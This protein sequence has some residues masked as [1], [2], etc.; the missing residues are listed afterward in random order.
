[1]ARRTKPDKSWGETKTRRMW[2][3]T[4]YMH[5]RIVIF[6]NETPSFRNTCMACVRWCSTRHQYEIDI[7]HEV[8]VDTKLMW[9]TLFH[10]FTHIVECE[11]EPE[12]L[13]PKKL[14]DENCT[15]LAQT[16]GFAMAQ[17]MEELRFC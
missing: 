4:N 12:A 1:M 17:M 14:R 2:A 10:E 5:W 6:D 13:S 9:S 3:R 11:V 15:R 7:A 8:L 16:M